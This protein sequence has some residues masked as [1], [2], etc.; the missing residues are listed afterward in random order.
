MFLDVF[1]PYPLN[2]K[3]YTGFQKRFS[4]IVAGWMQNNPLPPPRPPPVPPAVL[5]EDGRRRIMCHDSRRFFTVPQDHAVP[6]F[7]VACRTIHHFLH[8]VS[9]LPEDSTAVDAMADAVNA[10]CHTMLTGTQHGFARSGHVY[11]AQHVPSARAD[12]ETFAALAL[13]PPPEPNLK[14]VRRPDFLVPAPL[15]LWTGRWHRGE[16]PSW[17]AGDE[18]AL[19][20]GLV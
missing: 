11:D 18:A 20:C 14:R 16:G 12:G 5:T 15:A 8:V 2:L 9:L 13:E 3:T 1:V 19:P 17:W 7:C 10:I 4:S 6:H